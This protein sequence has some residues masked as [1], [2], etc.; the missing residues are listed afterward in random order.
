MS[1]VDAVHLV[2]FFSCLGFLVFENM[3]VRLCVMWVL[4]MLVRSA[5]KR[6][7]A[8]LVGAEVIVLAQEPGGWHQC[9][10]C[11]TDAIVRVNSKCLAAIPGKAQLAF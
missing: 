3:V 6:T 5:H 10:R 4:R 2:D 7:P 9:Q 1:L 11:D 8:D